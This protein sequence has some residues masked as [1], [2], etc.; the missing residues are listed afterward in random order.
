MLALGTAAHIDRICTVAPPAYMAQA[1]V[2]TYRDEIL[3]SDVLPELEELREGNEL[4]DI[5]LQV[6]FNVASIDL[7]AIIPRL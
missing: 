2:A 7:A 3:L 4:P 6:M 1:D 5:E